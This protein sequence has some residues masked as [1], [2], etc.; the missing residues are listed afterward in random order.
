MKDCV[1]VEVWLYAFLIWVLDD[2]KQSAWRRGRFIPKERSL[3]THWIG[4]LLWTLWRSEEF[5]PLPEIEPWISGRPAPTILTELSRLQGWFINNKQR[6]MWK[7]PVVTE[8]DALSWYLYGGELLPPVMVVC[9]LDE[10][11]TGHYESEAS[12][13]EP[14]SSVLC[15]A[16]LIEGVSREMV[17]FGPRPLVTFSSSDNRFSC[18]AHISG[19]CDFSVDIFLCHVYRFAFCKYDHIF[20]HFNCCMAFSFV[21]VIKSLRS[22]WD[23]KNQSRIIS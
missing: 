6:E 12:W 17:M 3:G 8:V 13:L 9:V 7:E 1:E 4:C 14:I 15:M 2:G 11:I 21:G 23:F 5:L 22:H 18:S 16:Y 10:I 19:S 20:G